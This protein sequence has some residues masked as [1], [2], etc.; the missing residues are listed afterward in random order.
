MKLKRL[1]PYLPVR[2]AE[3]RITMRIPN[4]L[5]NDVQKV[6]QAADESVHAVL[7][8]ALR[9]MIDEVLGNKST[10]TGEEDEK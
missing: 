6:A 7:I 9:L 2:E 1:L 8:A 5:Y 10:E 3:T 4:N